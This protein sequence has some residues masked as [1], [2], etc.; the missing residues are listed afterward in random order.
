MGVSTAKARDQMSDQELI[1][2]Y[3]ETEDS[4][5]IGDLYQRYA[6][7]VL[8]T[9]IRYLKNEAEGQDA[10]ADIFEELMDK[11]LKH[12]VSNFKSWL[13]TLARNHCLMKLRKKKPIKEVEL[14]E[15]KIQDQ[16]VEN[17]DF[18]H[19]NN[20]EQSQEDILHQALSQLKE[21]QKVC[22]E[23]FYL[24]EKSYKEVADITGYDL[25]KVKSYIQNGKRNLKLLLTKK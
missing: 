3:K 15:E 11:L 22:V 6:H 13:Y 19:L 12:E 21:P 18:E 4:R 16:F 20:E 5:F 25:K 8:G 24:K 2:K 7:L 9:C 14:E 1:N 23:L 17:P 10:V